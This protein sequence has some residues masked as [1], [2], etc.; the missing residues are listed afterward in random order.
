MEGIKM[1]IK[2]TKTQI[3]KI[4]KAKDLLLD[5]FYNGKLHRLTPYCIGDM[6]DCY[7]Q[8]IK[9]VEHYG[10][11]TYENVANL[12]KKCGFRVKKIETP[13]TLLHYH[14]SILTEK[15]I[16]DNNFNV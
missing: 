10:I 6:A 14:I 8:I 16:K 13:D 15:Q 3:K 4:L 11:T 1:E 7:N 2:L 12:F 9:S 5:M